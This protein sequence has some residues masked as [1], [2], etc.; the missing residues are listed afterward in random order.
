M[1][2]SPLDAIMEQIKAKLGPPSTAASTQLNHEAAIEETQDIPEVG[3]DE[4]E[5]VNEY[6]HF[7]D[8]E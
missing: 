5:F 2:K 1:S 8:E 3:I 7:S 6:E 4:S